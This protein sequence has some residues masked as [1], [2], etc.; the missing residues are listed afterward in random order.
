VLLH[1][2]IR[3]RRPGS[4]TLYVLV[5]SGLLMPATFAWWTGQPRTS[6]VGIIGFIGCGLA[7]IEGFSSVILGRRSARAARR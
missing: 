1:L 6:T 5:M 7:I 2:L 4:T 3:H